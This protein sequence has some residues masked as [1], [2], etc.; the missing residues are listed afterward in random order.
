MTLQ[1]R[2][3]I[4]EDL[5]NY[6][7]SQADS[8][9]QA[10][11]EAYLQNPWFVPEH[12]QHS[13]H[14][15]AEAFLKKDKLTEWVTEYSIPSENKNP[16]TIGIIMA[17]NMPLVGFHDWLCVFVSGHYSILKLSSK[18]TVLMQHLLQYLHSNYP[19]T[20][21]YFRI[22]EQLKGADA[23]IATGNN[24]SSRYFEYYFGKYPNIIRKNRSSVAILT[25]KETEADLKLLAVDMLLY[26]GMGCR[27]VTKIFVPNEYAFE[28]LLNAFENYQHYRDFHKF[29]HN[30]DYQ[31][32]LLIMNNKFYMTN[33]VII[34]T[35]QASVFAPISQVNYEYYDDVDH[36]INTLNQS[37]EIQCRVG[38]KGLPFGLAQ[39][40]TLTDYADGVDTLKFLL[41]L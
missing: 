8:W 31:L 32:A 23:Y 7:I 12:I 22:A 26:F 30:Y 28:P 15:I 39:K 40:P 29:K 4:L 20:T 9:L 34:L 36:L 35:E 5:G 24:N 10:Q 6:M 3:E 17:G 37:T 2:I 33:G 16:K 14:Q 19:E 38:Y 21:T 13:I 18:D 11:H 27:N 25:G 1:Q 41:D